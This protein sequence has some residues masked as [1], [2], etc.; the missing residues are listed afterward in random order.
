MQFGVPSRG[1]YGLV[2]SVGQNVACAN[3]H[4]A[5]VIRQKKRSLTHEPREKNDP[6][7]RI[8]HGGGAGNRISERPHPP[9]L[10]LSGLWGLVNARAVID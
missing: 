3:Q 2:L 10:A 6:R 8:G 4:C 5:G 9:M 1:R 7:G